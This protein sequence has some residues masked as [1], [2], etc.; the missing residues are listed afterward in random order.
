MSV[1]NTKKQSQAQA[2]DLKHRVLTC[3][4]KLSDR[5]THSAAAS[6][7]ESI[8]RSL[9]TDTLPPFLSSISA[10]DSSDKSP[11]RRQ[12]LRL[13]SVLSEHHGN[14]LS[15]YLSKLLTAIVRRLRDPDSSV[16]S[17][18]VSASLSLSSHVTAP[19][20]ASITKP[21]LE[22]L[23]REQ[24]SNTQ[25]GAALCLVS[26]IEGSQNPDS[27]SLKR[28]LPRFEKLAK[29][30]SFKAKAALLTLMG[31]VVE[32]NGVLSSSGK[33]L[34]KNLVMCFVEFV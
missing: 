1:F 9:S 32:L 15:P 17:A 23:F 20:F 8:A 4:H 26:L 11:V 29:C 33:N 28:L 6:E 30:E 31:S 24:D 12:C 25:T 27:G 34:I 16:R 13:I 5:D 7:L 10:T 18:C 22:S 2:R 19:S 14:S 3:L 21:F